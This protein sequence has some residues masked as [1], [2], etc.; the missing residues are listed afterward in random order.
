MLP[1]LV[2]VLFAFYLEG[3]LKFK[4]KIPAPKG[5]ALIEI[6]FRFFLPIYLL[7]LDSWFYPCLYVYFNRKIKRGEGDILISI[8]PKIMTLN[9]YSVYLHVLT[10]KN[11]VQNCWRRVSMR[12]YKIANGYC[13]LLHVRPSFHMEQLSFHW[14]DFDKTSYLNIWRKFLFKIE[15]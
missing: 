7:Q 9:H 13:Q 8:I 15:A 12:D 5:Y 10:F 2:P 4:C 11:E 3:V 6:S 14:T 1:C